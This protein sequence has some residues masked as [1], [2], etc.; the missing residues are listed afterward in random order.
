MKL[1]KIL[2][3]NYNGNE[4]EDSYWK[5]LNA[6]GAKRVLVVEA[7]A[8]NHIDADALLVKLGAKIDRKLIDNFSHLKYIGMLGTGYG[9]IDVKYAAL[10][11][12]TV[13]NIADYAIEGVAEFTIAILLEYLRS[14]AQA[15]A[16][17]K[18]G[19]FS[20]NFSGIEIKGKTFG[21]IGLGHIG[22]RT[23]ELAQAFGAHVIYWSKNRKK[24]IEQKGIKFSDNLFSQANI[25]TINLALN[26]ETENFLNAD[27]IA[28]I[29]KGAIVI[30]PSPMELLDFHALI[31]RL[32]KG[33]ITFMLD[34]SDEMTKEQL[35]ALKPFDNCIIY[36]PIAYLTAEA[37]KRKKRI[38]I[39]NLKNFIVGKPTNKVS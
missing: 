20:D 34:H 28:S 3:L 15:K 23:A 27:R 8:K 18:Q 14:V 1:K 13:T 22:A 9:G 39:D 24:E 31:S 37:S 11:N 25:I 7:D 19:N 16:Q 4:F 38:Y 17:A 29:K 36:P 12:I 35:E 30:N 21:V 10:K 33:D 5:E 2:C 32:K 26:P 6:F